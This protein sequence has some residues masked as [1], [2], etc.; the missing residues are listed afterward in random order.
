[1]VKGIN[2]SK[3]DTVGKTAQFDSDSSICVPHKR[4]GRVD[5]QYQRLDPHNHISYPLKSVYLD[6]VSGCLGRHW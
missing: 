5:I 4:R 3:Y 2:D 6:L 1:M